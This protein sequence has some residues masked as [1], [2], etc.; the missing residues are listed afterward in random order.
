MLRAPFAKQKLPG[1]AVV[2]TH[3]GGIYQLTSPPGDMHY[4]VSGKVISARSLIELFNSTISSL[5]RED[6]LKPLA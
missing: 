1:K 6:V 3:E 5:T 4:E 2:A